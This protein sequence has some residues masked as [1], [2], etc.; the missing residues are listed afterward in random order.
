[1]KIV[2]TLRD[3]GQRYHAAVERVRIFDVS[4]SVSWLLTAE[5]TR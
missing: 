2:F 5:R 3:T 1:M 4:W